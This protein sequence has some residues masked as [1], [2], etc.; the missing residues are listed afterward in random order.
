M[1][2][3]GTL[4]MF[5]YSINGMTVLRNLMTPRM[6][7]AVIVYEVILTFKAFEQVPCNELV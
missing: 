5:T 1:T 4:L 3:T 6:R 7:A 2:I